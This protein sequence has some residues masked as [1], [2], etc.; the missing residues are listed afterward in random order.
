MTWAPALAP[1]SEW[2]ACSHGAGRP[3]ALEAIQPTAKAAEVISNGGLR[4]N[5]G[6]SYGAAISIARSGVAF[7]FQGE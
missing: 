3:P 6:R 7:L 2:T 1:E 5:D 4:G